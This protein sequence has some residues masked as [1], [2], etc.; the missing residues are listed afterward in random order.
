VLTPALPA[1]SEFEPQPALSGP[2]TVEAGKTYTWTLD[3]GD[4]GHDVYVIL[5]SGSGTDPAYLGAAR[6]NDDDVATFTLTIPEDL[7]AGEHE[8]TY[9]TYGN[10]GEI[11]DVVRSTF[12]LAVTVAPEP[13]TTPT[14]PPTDAE[15]APP[16]DAATPPPTTA[17]VPPVAAAVPPTD[18]AVLPATGAGAAPPLL[19]SAV[20][21]LL[22]G[23]AAVYLNRRRS[24]KRH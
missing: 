3:G 19:G 10:H 5:Y 17:T 7:P 6:P 22:A 12:P 14:V 4:L 11:R 23:I 8:F 13:T 2:T 24:A 18:A 20:V 16:T 21:L 9:S 15:T 1:F